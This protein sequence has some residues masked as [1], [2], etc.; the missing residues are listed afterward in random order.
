[1]ITPASHQFPPPTCIYVFTLITSHVFIFWNVKV[2]VY[3]PNLDECMHLLMMICEVVMWA[4]HHH[5]LCS[6]VW[7]WQLVYLLTL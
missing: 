3:D 1:M 6:T 2:M 7:P 4:Y 5:L